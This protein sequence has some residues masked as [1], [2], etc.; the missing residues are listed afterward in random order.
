MSDDVSA[1]VAGGLYRPGSVMSCQPVTMG[2]VAYSAT[3]SAD[4]IWRG[5]VSRPAQPVCVNICA[6]IAYRVASLPLDKVK[7]IAQ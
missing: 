1:V 4:T 3:C 2:R 6:Q 5:A 7:T